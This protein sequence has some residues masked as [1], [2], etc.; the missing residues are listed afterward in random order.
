MADPVRRP[1]SKPPK[2]QQH[3]FLSDSWNLVP[4]HTRRVHV[5]EEQLWG[6]ARGDTPPWPTV[7]RVHDEDISYYCSCKTAALKLHTLHILVN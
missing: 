4:Q 2:G 5:P 7:F 6:T 3:P 1:F